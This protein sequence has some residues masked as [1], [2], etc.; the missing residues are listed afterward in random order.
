MCYLQARF[1]NK[2]KNVLIL[3]VMKP[4]HILI[5]VLLVV[6]LLS[7]C[8]TA[9]V[10]HP[11]QADLH[12]L[13]SSLPSAHKDFFQGREK[14]SFKD[15]Y[16]EA[17]GK[18]PGMDASQLYFSLRRLASFAQDSHTTVGLT[19]EFVQS[20]HAIPAQMIYLG[21]SWH[22]SVVETSS[23]GYLGAE[24]VAIN[25]VPMQEV[26]ALA[27]PLFGHDNEVWF[28]HSLS[29]QLNLTELYAYIGIA[30]QPTNEVTLTIV[31]LGETEQRTIRLLP[32]KATEYANRTFAILTQ[33]PAPTGPSQSYYRA[34]LLEN[35]PILFIQYNVC[36][37]DPS[38]P[39]SRFT[40]EVLKRIQQDQIPKAIIDLRY[41][42]GGDSR[43]FE[44]MI[45]GLKQIQ[46]D[47][48]LSLDVLIGENTFS[49]ALM[50]AKQCKERLACRLVGTPTGGSVNHY[51]EV[52]HFVLPNS[53]LPVFYSTKHFVMDKHH[54]GTSLEPDLYVDASVGDLLAG[55]D[56]VVETLLDTL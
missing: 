2:E 33:N 3:I 29:G 51:G 37:N 13:Y 27:K 55:R 6:A 38:L 53:K 54:K 45:A 40:E 43:L 16:E 5:S 52:K 9:V 19:Q 25:G 4:M 41:N 14:Q 39:M 56:T 17:L 30:E 44:P 12:E 11:Y 23:A 35:E 26:E 10:D 50:N 46:K 15:F 20:F 36:A 48:G 34:F 8:T 49:S 21:G 22:L 31:P 32:V 7:G 28:R 18:A 42:S 47:S 1:W 24:V